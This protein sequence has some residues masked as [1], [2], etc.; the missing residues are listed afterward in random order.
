MK[1]DDGQTVMLG[2]IVRVDLH[3]GDHVGRVIIIGDT[4]EYGGVDARTA[5]WALESGNVTVFLPYSLPPCLSQSHLVSALLVGMEEA[6]EDDQQQHR[7]PY[8]HQ[9]DVVP[10]VGH[11]TRRAGGGHP[12]LVDERTVDEVRKE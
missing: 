4:G 6:A 2:D 12:Q 8:R 5:K 11:G 1:Y 10:V 7:D 3:D 9:P